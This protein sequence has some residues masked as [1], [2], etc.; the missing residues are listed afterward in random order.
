MDATEKA[1]AYYEY[2]IKKSP[3]IQE[4]NKR[5]A[6][7]EKWIKETERIEKVQLKLNKIQNDRFREHYYTVHP[8]ERARHTELKESVTKE[9][10]RAVEEVRWEEERTKKKTPI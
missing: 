10:A 7:I 3:T 2:I 4:I 8:E 6:K 5:L 9:I 1:E